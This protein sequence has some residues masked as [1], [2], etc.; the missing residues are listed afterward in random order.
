MTVLLSLLCALDDM[1]G[2]PPRSEPE[3]QGGVGP[4]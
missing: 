4:G 3:Q 1:V 2:N